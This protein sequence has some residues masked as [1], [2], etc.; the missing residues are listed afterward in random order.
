M[1]PQIYL[2]FSF[3]TRRCTH[4]PFKIFFNLL[5]MRKK[6]TTLFCCRLIWLHLSLSPVS[7]TG[8]LHHT[9][10]KRKENFPPIGK[11]RMEQLQSHI[12]LTASPYMGKY[13]RISS[14]IR[15]PFFIYD[16]ASAPL[17]ISPIWGKFDFLFYQCRGRRKTQRKLR[18]EDRRSEKMKRNAK[19]EE[20]G[21]LYGSV[22][23]I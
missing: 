17:G 11:F 6:R 13:F 5:R 16:L 20:R 10:K 22:N 1:H 3:T 23:D 12:W 4:P 8:R 2:H 18:V 7:W 21:L 9:H 15:K 14:Y 19:L